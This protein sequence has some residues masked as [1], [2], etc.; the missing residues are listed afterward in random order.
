MSYY[1]SSDAY[2]LQ[3]MMPLISTLIIMWSVLSLSGLVNY[4]LRGLGIMKLS[5]RFGL[6]KGWLG[7]I[8]IA[9]EYQ[10][11]AMAGDIQLGKKQVKNPGLWLILLPII[12]FVSFFIVYIVMIIN[13]VS[14]AIALEGMGDYMVAMRISNML[15]GFFITLFILVFVV[16]I[17]QVITSIIR[18]MVLHRIFARFH[19]GQKPVFDMLIA[20]FVPFAEAILFLRRSKMDMIEP[21]PAPRHPQ[22]HPQPP[23]YPQQPQP[24]MQPPAQPPQI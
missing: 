18:I 20:I 7:F 10:L 23:V 17:I 12:S 13:L 2:A 11:G 6:D 24:P 8:P 22:Y 3:A 4:I 14:E 21:P 9:S 16:Y 15:G 19:A 5:E 1:S